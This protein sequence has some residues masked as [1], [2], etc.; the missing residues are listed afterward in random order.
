M[1]ETGV[2][3]NVPWRPHRRGAPH[4][5]YQHRDQRDTFAAPR[6][7]GSLATL[8]NRQ[9]DDVEVVESGTS[10]HCRPL[11]PATHS[12]TVSHGQ[13]PGSVIRVR[14]RVLSWQTVVSSISMYA[15]R[16]IVTGKPFATITTLGLRSRE[17]APTYQPACTSANDPNRCRR[18]A[19][20]QL[21][22]VRGVD[23]RQS[24]DGPATS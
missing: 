24:T 22:R 10:P 2:G 15:L 4:T 7:A 6:T 13:T 16:A 9:F 18:T 23:P 3:E 21:E 1:N 20:T 17:G 5:M 14:H 19:M 11:L 8:Q 12:V